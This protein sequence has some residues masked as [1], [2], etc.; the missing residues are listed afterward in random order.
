MNAPQTMTR[1]SWFAP[2]RGAS[3]HPAWKWWVTTVAVH[4]IWAG[5]FI[6]VYVTEK[7]QG[8]PQAWANFKP[9]A[10]IQGRHSMKSARKRGPAAA[11]LCAPKA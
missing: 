4:K 6:P 2:G 7:K 10:N 11:H 1:K 9:D 8:R 5:K 3:I